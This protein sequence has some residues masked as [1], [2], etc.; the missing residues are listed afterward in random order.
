MRVLTVSLSPYMVTVATKLDVPIKLVFEGPKKSSMLGLGDIVVPGIFIGLCLRFDHF[1]HYY[2]QRKLVPVELTTEV[3]S[4]AA[5][6]TSKETRRMVVKPEYADPQGRWGD[7][8][9]CG[10]I[11]SPDA[12]PALRASSFP[13]PYFHA[14]LVGYFLAMVFTM[15]MLLVF[16]HAQPAL[17]YLVPGVV[18]ATWVTGALRGELRDMWN[19]TEDGSLDKADV[20]VEVDGDGNVI[21]EVGDGKDASDKKDGDGPD[22][23]GPDDGAD[24]AKEGG[25]DNAA[26]AQKA[27][28][29]RRG[30]VEEEQARKRGYPVFLFSIEA[31]PPPS[32]KA[33]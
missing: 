22:G 12:T 31:P 2:R 26:A 19:Y 23:D 17:L 4:T 30:S 27:P 15:A 20:M 21:K 24:R 8:L 33:D 6:I 29:E 9:W 25:A 7:R 13:K 14:S 3:T 16:N 11:F 18:L 32:A 28:A 10:K 5:T 1:M